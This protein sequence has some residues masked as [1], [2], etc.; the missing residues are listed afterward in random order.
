MRRLRRSTLALTLLFAWACSDAPT[1]P[2]ES[3]AGPG[4]YRR[5]NSGVRTSGIN[6]VLVLPVRF[7]DGNAPPVT[8][9]ELQSRYFGG[10]EGGAVAE[11]Y[12]LASRGIFKLRGVVAPWSHS[13]IIY[14]DYRGAPQLTTTRSGDY[15]LEAMR[16]ADGTIDYGEFDN[17]G[18]DGFP[19]SGDDDGVVDG[20]VIVMNSDRDFYCD[21]GPGR[22]PHP[23]ANIRWLASNNLPHL[24][25][26]NS[27]N[28]GKIGVMGYTQ[29]SALACDGTSTNATVL[30]HELGHVLFAIPDLYHAIG[31]T[32]QIWETR[33]W[34]V[35]CWDLMASGSGWGCGSGA[36]A[37]A[38]GTMSTFSAWTRAL[39]FWVEPAVVRTDLDSTYTVHAFPGGGTVLRVPISATEYLLIEYREPGP[40]DRTPPAS[41]V[42]IYH[43]AEQLPMYPQAGGPRLYRASLI[44][45]DDEN[46]LT[47][48]QL[49]GGDRGK[50]SDAFGSTVRELRPGSHSRAQSVG[51]IPFPF[52]ISEITL[53][54]ALHQARLRITPR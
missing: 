51:G 20:G 26:D 32:G 2:R 36:P 15:V 44:E 17:D 27:K 33:R 47:R 42:L 39:N 54:P 35:G 12:S 40:G 23:H 3:D 19:N 1:A 5:S 18:P 37:F 38:S 28:G 49:E 52:V 16:A 22:G 6:R 41:G 14:R 8:V 50:A 10:T 4:P 48:T 11:T 21:D 24:T 30:A 13:Q 25:N 29:L 46:G 43:I 34:I 31:G 45:A 7:V 53:N 9:N